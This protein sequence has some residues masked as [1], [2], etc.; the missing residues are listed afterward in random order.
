[1]IQRIRQPITAIALVVTAIIAVA[2][3]ADSGGGGASA[4][5]DPKNIHITLS[6]AWPT[7]PIWTQT[8][9]FL[10]QQNPMHLWQFIHTLNSKRE[11]G[12]AYT[13]KAALDIALRAA[14][15]V[16]GDG[17]ATL[18]LLRYS[19]AINYYAPRIEMYRQMLQNELTAYNLAHP[20][21]ADKLSLDT[22]PI[23]VLSA[24]GAVSCDIPESVEPFT[25][26]GQPP[27][28]YD[29]DHVLGGGCNPVPPTVVLYAEMGSTHLE[30]AHTVLSD[31]AAACKIRYVLRPKIPHRARPLNVY[32]FGVELAIKNMEY[33]VIDDTKIRLDGLDSLQLDAN[34]GEAG[35]G[36]ADETDVNGFLF[37][38][39]LSRKPELAAELNAFRAEMLAAKPADDSDKVNVWDMREL[40]VQTAQRIS[41]SSDGL[42]LLQEVSQNFPSYASALTRIRVNSTLKAA[43]QSNQRMMPA[44]QNILLIN[45]MP[46]D[47]E[48]IDIYELHSLLTREA[49]TLDGLRGTRLSIE[50]IRSLLMIPP[51]KAEAD[52]G[53]GQGGQ[54]PQSP[55]K[56]DMGMYRMCRPMEMGV[57]SNMPVW[58]GVV[59]CGVVMVVMCCSASAETGNSDA[60][61]A[62]LNDITRDSR[63]TSWPNSVRELLQ[64]GW[65]NQLRYVRK[66]LYNAVI[67]IDPTSAAGLDFVR[68]ADVALDVALDVA[69]ALTCVVCWMLIWLWL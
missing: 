28:V 10:A 14:E 22:C 6:A 65:P 30:A 4:P 34:A 25:R 40:G 45:G 17:Q 44:G 21:A 2:A 26:A 49:Q 58:C 41:T 56:I 20:N 51:V 64:P 61:I 60:P 35:A 23:V 15:D 13:D 69:W 33:K 67:V 52:H 3:A 7:P 38:T 59:W 11:M 31:A 29:F 27:A 8:A 53:H 54:Q 24:N 36:G 19:L 12:V 66:N 63:Y 16:L 37:N 46:L 62:W 68:W 57:G 48:E 39:L 1:M 43:I 55:F 5:V 42:A 9:E 47:P 18:S 32:G 50:S